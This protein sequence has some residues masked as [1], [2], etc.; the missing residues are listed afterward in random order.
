M[1]SIVQVIDIYLTDN[2]LELLTARK[3]YI[4]KGSN[5]TI[6]I[7]TNDDGNSEW[8]FRKSLNEKKCF[9][10]RRSRRKR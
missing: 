9:P 3:V 1:I 10:V 2:R 8:N 6:E 5:I 7:K 4:K